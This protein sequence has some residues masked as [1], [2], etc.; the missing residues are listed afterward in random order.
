[1]PNLN[2]AKFTLTG[3]G[4]KRS[5]KDRLDDG[6]LNVMSFGA[7]GDGTT[8]DNVAIQAA[9]DAA[10]GSAI[11]DA[12]GS[13]SAT[14]TGKII[15]FPPGQY[16][17]TQPLVFKR[18]FG[19]NLIGAGRHQTRLFWSGPEVMG[20]GDTSDLSTPISSLIE[21]K[22]SQHVRIEG[23]TLDAGGV[24]DNVYRLMRY[25]TAPY[26]SSGTDG[27]YR[28]VHFTNGANTG[29][30]AWGDTFASEQL[31]EN[32]AFTNCPVYGVRI[33]QANALNHNFYNCYFANN[34]SGY[35][36]VVGGCGKFYG[37]RF[38][39]NSVVDIHHQ[40]AAAAIIYCYSTSKNFASADG[41]ILGCRH[42]GPVGGFFYTSSINVIP[43]DV[44]AGGWRTGTDGASVECIGNYSTN[45]N[46][47]GNS[48]AH[49]ML[50]GNRF[51][52]ASYL[53]GLEAGSIVRVDGV[54]Y[55]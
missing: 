20:E 55:P 42:D 41:T 46:L 6:F 31:Y 47:I 12:E 36:Q 22:D 32:C 25:S 44:G 29:V 9:L 11:G 39:N 13:A 33:I 24:Q 8:P 37:C 16:K 48:S 53:G 10:G 35:D 5:L 3:M 40:Q 19:A 15:R 52:N 50:T 1:M 51:D 7:T 26:H 27:H 49:V 21:A 38:Y 54:P 43:G 30:L 18:L 4:M 2:T 23:M 28:D 45:G 17:I 34:G 14:T